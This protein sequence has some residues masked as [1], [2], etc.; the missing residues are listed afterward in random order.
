M[1]PFTL[2][3]DIVKEAIRDENS[4]ILL[5]VMRQ[6]ADRWENELKKISMPHLEI[7]PGDAVITPRMICLVPNDKRTR[8]SRHA[9]ETEIFFAVDWRT[10]YE[11]GFV[12]GMMFDPVPDWCWWYWSGRRFIK[13]VLKERQNLS[14]DVKYAARKALHRATETFE[15]GRNCEAPDAMFEAKTFS[16]AAHIDAHTMAGMGMNEFTHLLVEKTKLLLPLVHLF[17][18]CE[19]RADHNG[20]GDICVIRIA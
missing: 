4:K 13:T 2:I 6:I 12:L 15:L 8:D 20:E 7:C 11:P 14:P 16:L 9:V 3:L 1:T 17:T 10:Q 19:Y 18:D 5:P